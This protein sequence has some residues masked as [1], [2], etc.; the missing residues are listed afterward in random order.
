MEMHRVKRV[1][2]AIFL[3]AG[4]A[5]AVEAQDS[6]LVQGMKYRVDTLIHTH[7]VGHGTLH[8]YY[9]LPDLPLLVN[10]LVVDARHPRVRLET[11][12][13]RDSLVGLERPSAMAARRSYPGHQVFAA[14]NGDFYNTV[15]P[16]QGVPVNGQ[17]INGELARVPH[18][19]RPLLAFD[20]HLVRFID[21]MTFSGSVTG[22][23]ETIALAGVNETRDTDELILF[24]GWFGRTTRTNQWG[25]EVTCTLA[26]G[27]K[28]MIN[29]L[30][31]LKVEAKYT[32]TGSAVIAPGRMVL[33]GHGVAAAFLNRLTPGDTLT[34]E[35]RIALKNEPSLFPA[36]TGMV[37]GDRQILRDGVVQENNWVELHPRTA[38]G[39]S[40]DGARI[41]LAVVDGRTD[42]SK[43][44]STKQLADIMKASGAA[45]ALNLDGGGSSVMVVRGAIKNSPSDGAE[46]AVGN[47]LLVISA[48][49]PGQG[50]HM[51]LNAR[52]ITI[53]FGR[54]FH[55]RGSIFDD[56]GGMVSYLNAENMTYAV[57]GNIGHI[58]GEGW[59]TASGSGGSGIITGTW[60]GINDT[61]T[62]LVKAAEKIGFGTRKLLIDDRR[63]YVFKVYGTGSDGVPYLIDNE[64]LRFVSLDG[65]VGRVD[66][67]GRF[68]GL[69]EGRVGVVVRAGDSLHADTCMVDVEVGRG[70]MLIDD[71][72]DPATWSPSLSYIDQVALKREKHPLTQE[73]MLRVDYAFVYSNRTA[74]I[75]LTKEIPL[76]GM[77]DSLMLEAAGTGYQNAYYYIVDHTAG[78]CQVPSFTSDVVAAR[79]A[80]LRTAEIRQEDYP[81]MLKTIR[82]IVE[83]DPS[84]VQGTRYTGTFWLKG[85]Y[86]VYPTPL[87][88]LVRPALLPQEWVFPNPAREGFYLQG[89][90]FSG[91]T[92][93]SL[94]TLRGEKIR[95]WEV[96]LAPGVSSGFLPLGNLPAGSYIWV[97]N[98]TS[99]PIQGKL[100]VLP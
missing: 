72:S 9:R 40:A 3:A 85:L 46:R 47:A 14:V 59:F 35:V 32:G 53:P 21:V 54:K 98:G 66:A 70:R 17:I 83:R 75:T 56:E 1:V 28:P 13:G 10:T 100:I 4:W 26:E 91:K 39:Y 37:G 55:V 82:L 38:A 90:H 68:R 89:G 27:E 95:E 73:E 49:G 84:Y 48:A 86:A 36:L 87:S 93:V 65:S 69:K 11:C 33:S 6:L 74:S 62:V 60:Q 43:G 42:Q 67:M 12:L 22:R 50:S 63:D 2:L 29:R 58:D 51:Q 71:F 16:N 8:T 41:I 52:H 30:M 31:R 78:L 15:S 44:V 45:H 23:G 96:V 92:R 20:D 19:S 80:A 97:A 99:A 79:P 77:P 57:T 76:Y 34:A 7:D 18:A 24:N 81:L 94:Y 25:T 88:R 61:M 64:I 5:G